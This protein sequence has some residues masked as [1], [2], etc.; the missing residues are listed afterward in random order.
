MWYDE[1]LGEQHRWA[2][3]TRICVSA[4]GCSFR[5]VVN[6]GKDL[7]TLGSAYLNIMWP[8]ELSNEKWL[9]YPASM[10]LDDHPDTQCVLPAALNPLNPLKLRSQSPATPALAANHTVRRRAFS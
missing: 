1:R 10:S 4:L 9:L 6:A 5:Q 2:K 8:Y 7:E 3:E